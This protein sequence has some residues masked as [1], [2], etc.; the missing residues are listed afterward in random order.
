MLL[1]LH[2][3]LTTVLDYRGF[4]LIATSQL[5]IAPSTLVYGSEDGGNTVYNDC[6]EFHDIMERCATVLN[7]KVCSDA[8]K[9]FGA[10][11]PTDSARI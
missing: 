1:G 6:S 10:R 8:E 2:C 7:L 5:P 3:G 4:R 11:R 9:V